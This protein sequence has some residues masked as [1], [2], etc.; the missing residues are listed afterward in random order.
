MYGAME[1]QLTSGVNDGIIEPGARL[2]NAFEVEIE[3]F[4]SST[5]NNILTKQLQT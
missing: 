2:W 4:L 3:I 5:S 1:F